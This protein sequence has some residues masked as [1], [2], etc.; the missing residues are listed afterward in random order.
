[1]TIEG[2]MTGTLAEARELMTLA[3][4]GRLTPIPISERPLAVAQS[5]LD[6]LRAGRVHGRVVLVP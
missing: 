3:R 1:M 2:T 6:D 4:E 5:A